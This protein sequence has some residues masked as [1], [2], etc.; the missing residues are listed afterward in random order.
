MIFFFFKQKTAYEVSLGLVG[1]E[2]C[3][4]DRSNGLVII[5]GKNGSKI[6][7]KNIGFIIDTEI[8]DIDADRVQEIACVKAITEEFSD[9]PTIVVSIVSLYQYEVEKEIDFGIV[10]LDNYDGCLVG[11]YD[12]NGVDDLLIIREDLIIYVSQQT[13]KSKVGV[14]IFLICLILCV[15]F[16]CYIRKIPPKVRDYKW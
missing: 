5:D 12:N 3:I 11:D 15:R 8:L 7:E 9:I 10:D 1:S 16:I 6:V 14:P 13:E 2:M 4:R